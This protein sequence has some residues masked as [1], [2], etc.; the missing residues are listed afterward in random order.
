VSAGTGSSPSN[1]RSARPVG[2]ALVGYGYRGRNLARNT[3]AAE[4]L[5]LVAIPDGFADWRTAAAAQ[6]PEGVAVI[7]P[8]VALG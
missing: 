8:I 4:G 5:R 6:Y 3:Q 2:V 7:H 1:D